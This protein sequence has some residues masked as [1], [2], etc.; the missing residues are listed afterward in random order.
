M[1]LALGKSASLFALA[2]IFKFLISV[3]FWLKYPIIGP[4]PNG[5][6]FAKDLALSEAYTSNAL[7][8]TATEPVS[9]YLVT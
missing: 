9:L 3:S 5:F 4:I 1:I 2:I 8:N 7:S 6:L